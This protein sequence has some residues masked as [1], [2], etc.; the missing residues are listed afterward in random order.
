MAASVGAGVEVL[1][2]SVAVAVLVA[3]AVDQIGRIAESRSR[4]RGD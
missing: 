3:A 2:A 1:A 4:T